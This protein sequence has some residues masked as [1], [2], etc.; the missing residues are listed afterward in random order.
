M[1]LLGETATAAKA[2]WLLALLAALIALAALVLSVDDAEAAFPGTNGMIAFGSTMDTPFE[3]IYVQNPD[4]SGFLR[5]TNNNAVDVSPTWSP[6]GR[7]IAFASDR[8]GDFEI[9]VM[10]SDGTDVVKLTQNDASDISPTWSPDGRRIAFASDRDGNYEV[11]VIDLERGTE[12][13]IT[14]N[15][16]W[17]LSPAASPSC[18]TATAT[19]R[20]TPWSLTE[21]IR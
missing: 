5:L 14:N 21:A 7:R 18:R 12:T 15:P 8:D 6:D 1:R 3:E 20:S 11:Y 16:A 13:N 19:T 10:A 17:D 2:R 9:Y 4:G